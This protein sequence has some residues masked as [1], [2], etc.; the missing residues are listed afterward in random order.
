MDEDPASRQRGDPLVRLVLP[1]GA[2]DWEYGTVLRLRTH[3]RRHEYVYMFVKR[4]PRGIMPNGDPNDRSMT[5]YC[6]GIPDCSGCR[7]WDHGVVGTTHGSYGGLP[8]ESS[9]E[10]IG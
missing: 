9:W 1:P 8:G 6:L 5:L 7:E 2:K 4:N 3:D 10:E